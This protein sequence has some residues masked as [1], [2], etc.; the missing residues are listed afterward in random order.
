[1]IPLGNAGEG[2][3]VRIKNIH[4]E[5]RL[6]KRMCDLGLYPGMKITVVKN[7]RNGPVVLQV[8]ES[9][10]ML[11]RDQANDIQVEELK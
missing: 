8:L 1:M 7:D 11:G 4:V 2:R 6:G 5:E 3:N 10:L 9:K